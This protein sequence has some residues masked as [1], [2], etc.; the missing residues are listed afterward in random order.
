VEAYT[1]G[2]VWVAGGSIGVGGRAKTKLLAGWLLIQDSVI[3]I[4]VALPAWAVRACCAPG[5]GAR[6]A[7]STILGIGTPRVAGESLGLPLSVEI[8]GLGN[9]VPAS[10]GEIGE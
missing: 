7:G 2:I 4:G 8:E 9:C 5:N 1:R 6:I 10:G 3:S